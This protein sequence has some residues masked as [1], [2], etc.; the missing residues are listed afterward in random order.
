MWQNNDHSLGRHIID[1]L[2]GAALSDEGSLGS[3]YYDNNNPSTIVLLFISCFIYLTMSYLSDIVK[4]DPNL[5]P[6]VPVIGR[7]AEELFPVHR[8]RRVHYVIY[9]CHD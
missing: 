2:A 4:V 7:I 3:S 5:V 9:A 6:V 1:G 8:V